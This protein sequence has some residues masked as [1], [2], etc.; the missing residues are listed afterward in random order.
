MRN[1]LWVGGLC[2]AM[3]ASAAAVDTELPNAAMQGDKDGVLS[4]LKAKADVN[5][6]Q[7]DGMTALHWAA[8]RDDVELAKTLVQAGA[9][10]KATTRDGGLTPLSMAATNGSAAMIK[11]LLEAGA[12]PNSRFVHGTTPLMLASASGSGDAVLACSIRE[13][14]RMLAKR[15]TG[16]RQRCSRQPR[17]AP[18]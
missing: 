12:D 8:F 2:L 6:A 1:T 5:A 17:I 11:V 4:L 16:K 7:G 3:L 9:N 18:Q 14:T 13:R 10:V 15:R